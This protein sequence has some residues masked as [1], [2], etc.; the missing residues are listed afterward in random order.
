MTTTALTRVF[1]GPTRPR[2]APFGM[3][4]PPFI[5]PLSVRL[6]DRNYLLLSKE[7]V[8]NINI[9]AEVVHD[10]YCDNE[11]QF[12]GTVLCS[13][14]LNGGTYVVVR[15][16]HSPSHRHDNTD[17]SRSC[18]PAEFRAL[19]HGRERQRQPLFG[20]REPRD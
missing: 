6:T 16:H 20:P 8:R 14:S 17:R 4:G 12:E 13:L 18:L 10:I 5:S 3:R 15:A 11:W 9:V 7:R 1:R 19:R 2:H